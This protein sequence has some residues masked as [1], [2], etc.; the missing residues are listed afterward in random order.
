MRNRSAS[1]NGKR[2]GYKLVKDVAS[3]IVAVLAFSFLS[4][5]TPAHAS[6]EDVLVS[7]GKAVP[8]IV[9]G[10]TAKEREA[11]IMFIRAFFASERGEEDTCRA[12]A[13]GIIVKFIMTPVKAGRKSL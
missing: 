4:T 13:K 6:C 12:Y 1:F 7:L 2:G 5:A 9:A 8:N 10:H 11:Q 3:V